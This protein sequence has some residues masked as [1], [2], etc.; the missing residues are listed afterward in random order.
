MAT[1]RWHIG[2]IFRTP[3]S[4]SFAQDN[5]IQ[6]PGKSF[7]FNDLYEFSLSKHG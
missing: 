1:K 4:L 5:E 3:I 7:I 6:K 2:A